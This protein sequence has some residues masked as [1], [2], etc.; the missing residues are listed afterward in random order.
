MDFSGRSG[1]MEIFAKVAQ[2]GSLSAAARALGLT[3]SAVSRILARTEQRLGTRLLLR[4]TRRISLTFEGAAFLE[5]CQRILRELADAEGDQAIDD[6]L[7]DDGGR[8]GGDPAD[9]CG[10]PARSGGDCS[11]DMATP[12]RAGDVARARADRR[13]RHH[14]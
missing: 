7:A 1:E 9:P 14:L 4:T 6:L 8:N 3:P 12:E 10:R 13:D 2:A 5:E 11:G